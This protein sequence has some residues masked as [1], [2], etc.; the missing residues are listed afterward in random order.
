M[1]DQE[2][3]SSYN[4]ISILSI[5]VMRI[6]QYHNIT[7]ELTIKVKKITVMIAN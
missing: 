4:I 2:R 1:S 5:E 7:L 3:I 6:S